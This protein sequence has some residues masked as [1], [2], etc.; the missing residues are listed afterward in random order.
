MISPVWDFDFNEMA[1]INGNGDH[2][3]DPEKAENHFAV[4]AG[5]IETESHTVIF[6]KLDDEPVAYDVDV[7][8]QQHVSFDD[9]LEV[10]GR[11]TGSV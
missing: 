9:D 11:S 8:V 6:D 4:V 3:H 7:L 1:K 2:G 5:K 10:S